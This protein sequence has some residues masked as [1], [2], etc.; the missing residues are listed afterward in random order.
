MYNPAIVTT[1]EIPEKIIPAMESI[2]FNSVRKV[3]P[4]SVIQT[5]CTEVGYTYRERKITPILTIFHM[6]LAAIWP[7]ES[8]QASWQVLWATWV[9]WFP[10]L[11]GKSPCRSKVSEARSRLPLALWSGIFDWISRQVQ[12]LSDTRARWRGHRVVLLDG[13]CVSMADQPEL[14][15]SFG[16]STG[17]NGKGKYPLAR[18][19]T[20]S[21]AHTMTVISYALGRYKQDENTLARPLLK[22][23]RRGDLVVADRHFAGAHL[24]YTYQNQGLEFLTRAH[25]RLKISRIKR[26]LSYSRNDF[27]GWL[28]IGPNYL[29]N[30]PLLPQKIKVRFIRATVRIRQQR[31]TIWLVTSLLDSHAYPARE[32]VALYGRR[33]RIETLFKELKIP[34]SAD[35]LRSQTPAGI[36]KEVAARLVAINIVRTIMLEAALQENVDPIQI[37]FVHSVRAILSFSPRFATGPIR[38]LPEIYQTMLAEIASHLVPERP[39]RNEPRCVR[40]ERIHYPSLSLTRKEWRKKYCA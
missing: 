15:Q 25:Q 38:Q 4:D 21:L 1:K 29:R 24:Y 13:T 28:K 34:F 39:G 6:I 18:I 30:D 12:T 14:F 11:Q 27:V 22:R 26:I 3:L 40:R 19:V 33:W 10:H 23:L 8:F 2:T 36:R 20:L 37:S 35:V 7:E 17:P 16:T 31:Q 9:S 32:I 5:V